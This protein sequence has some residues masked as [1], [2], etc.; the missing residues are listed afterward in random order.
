MNIA[1]LPGTD[2]RKIFFDLEDDILSI[3][4][5]VALLVTL[6]QADLDSDERLGLHRLACEVQDHAIAVRDGFRKAF[7]GPEEVQ[8]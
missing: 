6:T 1:K 4:E 3:A 8:S 2:H 7:G 5:Y